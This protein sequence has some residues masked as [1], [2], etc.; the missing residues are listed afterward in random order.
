[1]ETKT[2]CFLPAN[3]LLPSEKAMSEVWPIVAC[4][5]YV[6]QPE[7]WQYVSTIV[8]NMPSS[9]R[10]ILP[11]TYLEECEKQIPAIKETMRTYLKNHILTEQVNQG[12]VLVERVTESGTR[13]GLVGNIDL[14]AYSIEINSQSPI[15]ATE[16][17]VPSRI[18]P[19]VEIRQQA[20]I[21]VPHVMLLINDIKNQLIEPIYAKKEYL[22]CLYNLKLMEKGGI[23]R[24]YAVEK[25]D[26]QKICHMI[27]A[28]QKESN[29]LFLAVGDGNHSL[30]AA[31]IHWDKLKTIL[32]KAELHQHPARYALV[33][34]VNLHCPAIKFEPIHRVVFHVNVEHIISAFKEY[35]K[36]RKMAMIPGSTLRIVRSDIEVNISIAGLNG[37][38]PVE[39][40]QD[41]LNYYET[42]NP[43]ISI[44]YVHGKGEAICLA[45]K[46]L[47][48]GFLLNSID[49]TALFPAIEEGGVLPR[50][51]F[52]MGNANEKRYYMECRK[53]V[54]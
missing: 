32:S 44:D 3:I 24:G 9:L 52:S 25:Y 14:E 30:A 19:R 36:V 53:I 28:L 43:N 51:T 11:E 38:L 16:G 15:R 31:K 26:A 48:C 27:S 17:V 20:S 22:K 47:C 7:Y 46:P 39:I 12:F 42:E 5:Q 41:F 10:L 34:L 13:I 49:K 4:D 54:V 45:K 8:G 50:K 35:L 6:S 40:L 18:P 29:G 33:E 37:L 2:P 1:M 21:E 23:L